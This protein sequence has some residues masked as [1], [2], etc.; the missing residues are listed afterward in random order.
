MMVAQKFHEIFTTR[1]VSI[2]MNNDAGEDPLHS[3]ITIIE[4]GYYDDAVRGLWKQFV[5]Q[6][7]TAADAWQVSEIREALLCGRMNSR[8]EFTAESC[9]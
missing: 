1:Y 6:R 2:K 5:L 3:V 7:K 4:D 8:A 9:P